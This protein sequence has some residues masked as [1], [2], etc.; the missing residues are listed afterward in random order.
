MPAN[1]KKRI[2]CFGDSNTWGYIPNTD[3][4]RFDENSRYPKVLQKLLGEDYEIIEEG[5]NSRTLKSEDLRPGK[6]NKN[7]SK[8]L[9]PCLEAHDPIDLII[10]MIGINEL[11]HSYQKTAYEAAQ[12]F[13]DYYIRL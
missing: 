8:H 6:D 5:L 3:H 11:K 4:Q 7:G 2:L 10:L 13:E 1:T 9:I 12:V